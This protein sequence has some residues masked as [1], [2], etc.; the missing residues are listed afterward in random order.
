MHICKYIC[1]QVHIYVHMHAP[2]IYFLKKAHASERA[3]QCHTQGFLRGVNGEK[4]AGLL[5]MNL[6]VASHLGLARKPI[7]QGAG[8]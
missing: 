8:R 7:P 2:N 6:S 3:N 4:S 5:S 1:R